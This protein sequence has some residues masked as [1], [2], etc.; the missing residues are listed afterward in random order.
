[1][2]NIRSWT[3]RK[4]IGTQT[5]PRYIWRKFTFQRTDTGWV[6]HGECYIEVVKT[7]DYVRPFTI[8]LYSHPPIHGD[9]VCELRYS[10]RSYSVQWGLE[11]MAKE[12][13]LDLTKG[14]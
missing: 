7:D 10:M 6:H 12:G 9:N 14:A 5:K 3:V 1:M 8:T 4:N 2:S 11:R 13:F